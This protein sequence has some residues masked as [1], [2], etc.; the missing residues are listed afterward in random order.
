M[1]KRKVIDGAE[2]RLFSVAEAQT[3]L[4]SGRAATMQI[5][6]D[7]GAVVRIGRR[8]LI[9]KRELDKGID[10]LRA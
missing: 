6:E 9:D 5:A 7:C 4:G 10:L 2:I 8:V 3:Y 1:Q